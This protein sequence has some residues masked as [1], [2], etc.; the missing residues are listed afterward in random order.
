MA[1]APYGMCDKHD[2]PLEVLFQAPFCPLCEE[3]KRQKA[4]KKE[5]CGKKEG[6][7][8]DCADDG[9]CD[10]DSCDTCGGGCTDV[11]AWKQLGFPWS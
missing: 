7:C 3:E 1:G 11:D 2:V 10:E 9:G 4:C 8:G 6:D 5:G